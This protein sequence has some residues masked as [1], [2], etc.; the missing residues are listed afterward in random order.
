V[1][2]G[3][4]RDFVGLPASDNVSTF[5]GEGVERDVV[6]LAVVDDGLT[7]QAYIQSGALSAI[8]L[9]GKHG[10]LAQ[11]KN[12]MPRPAQILKGYIDRAARKG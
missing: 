8:R 4:D 6:A 12:L 9:M 3:L 2:V 11:V 5:R 1:A 10:K 7:L